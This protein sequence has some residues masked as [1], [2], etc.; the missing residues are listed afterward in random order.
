[1]SIKFL[2]NDAI[3]VYVASPENGLMTTLY[4]SMNVNFCRIK[5]TTFEKDPREIY[6]K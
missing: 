5:N 4:L 2:F 6:D 3:F 1:M